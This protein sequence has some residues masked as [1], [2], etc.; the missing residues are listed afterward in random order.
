MGCPSN[1]A[2][3]RWG[4]PPTL[5][6]RLCALPLRYF[7]EQ[8]QRAVL[9]PTLLAATCGGAHEG[10]H[11]LRV[12]ALEMA[13]AALAQYLDDQPPEQQGPQQQLL[14]R[15]ALQARFP[16]ALWPEAREQLAAAEALAA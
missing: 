13:P 9:M 8:R 12:L 3:L 6:Q 1:A 4:P 14:G 2:V 5:L 16:R 11:N 10:G 7:T 15:F